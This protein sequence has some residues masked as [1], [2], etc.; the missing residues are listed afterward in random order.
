M[1]DVVNRA[2]KEN[3]T[4]WLYCKHRTTKGIMCTSKATVGKIELDGDIRYVLIDYTF[5]NNHPGT[6]GHVISENMKFEMCK[7]AE[8]NSEKPA[9]EARNAAIKEFAKKNERNPDLWS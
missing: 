2:N 8:K 5:E 3:P 9:S 4:F 7:R 1:Q 6:M